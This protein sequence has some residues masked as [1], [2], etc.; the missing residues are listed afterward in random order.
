MSSAKASF[1]TNALS[2]VSMPC[3]PL[4]IFTE[5][6][7][8]HRAYLAKVPHELSEKEFWTA[9]FKEQYKRLARR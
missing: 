6:P 2:S 9:Y 7:E 1:Y 5:R 3:F 4:Q 8:V